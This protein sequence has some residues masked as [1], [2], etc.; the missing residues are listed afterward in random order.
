MMVLSRSFRKVVF[1]LRC[2]T[3]II[4]ALLSQPVGSVVVSVAVELFMIPS[5]DSYEKALRVLMVSNA[6]N[7]EAEN[8]K[9]ATLRDDKLNTP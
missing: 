5:T 2:S 4:S 8:E 1:H 7:I 9:W 6:D 3:K